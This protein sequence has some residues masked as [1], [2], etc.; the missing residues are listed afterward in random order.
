M[1]WQDIDLEIG[2]W[3][4]PLDFTKNGEIHRVPLTPAAVTILKER[5]PC[6]RPEAEWVFDTFDRRRSRV[7]NSETS[8]PAARRP[9]PFYPAAMRTAETAEPCLG[10]VLRFS[11]ASPSPFRDMICV[12]PRRPEWHGPVCDEMTLRRS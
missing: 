4:I 5:R 2:W 11:P 10:A 6:T 8:L 7:E 3:E 9:Q 1:R 12:A